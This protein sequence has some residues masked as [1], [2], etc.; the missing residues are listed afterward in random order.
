MAESDSDDESGNPLKRK[1]QSL[2][3]SVRAIHLIYLFVAFIF[4]ILA[5]LYSMLAMRCEGNQWPTS[6]V[7][8]LS[9]KP[10]N[11]LF[12]TSQSSTAN[13]NSQLSLL[14]DRAA[15]RF[16]FLLIIF[17]LLL[18]GIENSSI[19][20]IYSFG[21]EL[22]YTERRSLLLQFVFFLGLLIGR[23][24]DLCVDYGCYLFNTRITNRTKKQSE[25]FHLLSI[26]FCI[27][28][29]LTF[30]V[31]LCSTLSFSHLFQDKN[32]TQSAIP[33][34]QMFYVLF[35]LIGCF[36]GS[37][38]TLIL[39]WIER[40]LS[41]NDSLIRILLIVTTIS[42]TLF[43]AFLFYVIKHRSLS[44][45]FY[46]FLISCCLLALFIG[47]LH[48]GKRWQR[49]KL[50]RVLPTSMDLDE[51]EL[52]NHSD[53]EQDEMEFRSNLRSNGNHFESERNK[54]LKGH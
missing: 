40:D 17:Y 22:N 28:I 39:F 46:L 30:L 2:F 37:L 36:I 12:G 53:N 31:L 9:F 27:L 35:F 45:L 26:K 15:W 24:V 8:S 13:N 23:V 7:N 1:F 3:N 52:E 34:A 33:T 20:L 44:Y 49:K 14:S 6:T 5:V 4:L 16:V 38:A 50:Y 19:Y 51:V 48:S 42:E 41:L 18:A 29:R 11:L 10:L 47:I 25:K 21:R 54:G 43:P 32:Q